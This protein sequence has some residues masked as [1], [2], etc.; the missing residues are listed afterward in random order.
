M[1]A[2]IGQFLMTRFPEKRVVTVTEYEALRQRIASLDAEISGLRSQLND[3]SLSLN[4]AIS[5]IGTL[6]AHSVHKGAVQD[7]VDVIRQVKDEMASL[8]AG[9]GMNRVG[10]ADIRALLN[11]E[12]VG[13]QQ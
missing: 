10:D 2:K 9:L 5:R 3:T 6:E 4:T 12:P 13:D 1:L 7:L 11:G 8:K